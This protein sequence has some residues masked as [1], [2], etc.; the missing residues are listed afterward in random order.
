MAIFKWDLFSSF[1][2]MIHGTRRASYPNTGA[3][4]AYKQLDLY[5]E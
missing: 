2:E 3:T 4:L 5:S 1:K